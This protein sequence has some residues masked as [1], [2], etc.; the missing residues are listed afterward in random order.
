MRRSHDVVDGDGRVREGVECRCI[1]VV[2]EDERLL[3]LELGFDEVESVDVAVDVANALRSGGLVRS[4]I[5][6]SDLLF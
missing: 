2:Y 6:G 5:R 4:A 1:D 3:Q